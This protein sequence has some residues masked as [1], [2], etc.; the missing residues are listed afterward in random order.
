MEQCR[1]AETGRDRVTTENKKLVKTLEAYR[2]H[3][4]TKT[5]QAEELTSEV[6]PCDRTHQCSCL[7]WHDRF[8]G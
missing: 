8:Y 4:R 1:V 2:E 7:Q 5:L 3:N 6:C